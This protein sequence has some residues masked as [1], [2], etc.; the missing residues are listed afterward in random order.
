ME[1]LLVNADKTKGNDNFNYWPLFDHNSE[2]F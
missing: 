1:E 2:N